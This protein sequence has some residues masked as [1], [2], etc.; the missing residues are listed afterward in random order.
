MLG[1]VDVRRH[2]FTRYRRLA[3]MYHGGLFLGDI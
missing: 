3:L 2:M 1:A